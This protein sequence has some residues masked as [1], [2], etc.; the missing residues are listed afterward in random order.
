VA[1]KRLILVLDRSG[2]AGGAAPD[3]ERILSA[4]PG[5]QRVY[6]SATLETVYVAYDPEQCSPARLATALARNGIR[7]DATR[8]G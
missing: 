2:P 4:Q 1:T 6:A 5:V 7:I 8:A 3:A